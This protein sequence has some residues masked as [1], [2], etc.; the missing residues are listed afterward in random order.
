MHVVRAPIWG[1]ALVFLAAVFAAT[2]CA[3][4]S[5][6]GQPWSLTAVDAGPTDTGRDTDVRDTVEPDT[7]PPP[8]TVPPDTIPP[9]TSPRDT[10]DTTDIADTVDTRRDTGGCRGSPVADG[11]GEPACPER[12]NGL[13]DDFDGRIDEGAD[14]GPLERSCYTGPPGTAGVRPCREGHKLCIDGSWSECRDER[15]PKDEQCANSRDDDCDGE[16][17]ESSQIREGFEGSDPAW[18]KY[19]QKTVQSRPGSASDFRIDPDAGRAA[20]GNE[21]G[22]AR[23]RRYGTCGYGGLAKRYSLDAPPDELTVT[24][25]VRTDSWGRANILLKEGSEHHVLWEK[26][27]GGSPV[28]FDWRTETFDLTDYGRQFTLIIGN[29][30][31]STP[32]CHKISDHSWQIWA[33]DIEITNECSGS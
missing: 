31:Q 2:G 16:V 22:T 27:G 9:D 8:D 18:S 15:T 4:E 23:G 28:R 10:A 33:D 11:S 12:C 1:L 13:D 20:S 30:D 17:D 24:F 5:Y 21:S 6:R 32:W 7:R 29:A 26:K 14:A 3:E 25:R 19:F